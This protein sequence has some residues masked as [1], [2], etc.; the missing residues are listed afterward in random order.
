MKKIVVAAD[1]FKGSVTSGEVAQSVERGIL[2]VFPGCRVCKAYVAD[3]GEGTAQA[4]VETLGGNYVGLTV[5]D[6][7]MRPVAAR[8]G[9]VDDGGTAIVEMASASGLTLVEPD[10]RN[11]LLTTTFGS[12]ELILNA[13]ERGCRRIVI[14]I[15]GS[16]TNDA[17]TGLLQAL[18]FRFLDADG[19]PL[20]EGANGGMLSTIASIDPSEVIP[21]VGEA[22]F[23][24]ACDVTNPF[25]GPD[26]AAHVYAP[27]K[28]ADAQ[29]VATLDEGLRRF[30]GV[31]KHHNGADSDRIPG[32]GAAGGVVG[33]GKA[34]LGASLV[35]GIA[36]VLEAIHFDE[37]L[38]DADLVITGEGRL[39]AQTAM[40][41][42]PRGVLD[43][44]AR[45]GIPVIA[46]GGAVE[47]TEELLR[48][49]FAA[50]FPVVPAPVA[51]EKAMEN[52][53]ARANIERTVGQIMR[54]IALSR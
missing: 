1:S 47:G 35:P 28:G 21:A 4:L 54:L 5:R 37:M 9:I 41:K 22:E 18:G 16:A 25:S 10:R 32:A 6:P 27:Q 24:V 39:D 51:L 45:Q 43:A 50:V 19:D 36:V 26:G 12:G 52:G 13:L 30:A 23:I 2:S 31:V 8:Y 53:Y 38:H 11:P 17:G 7:L 34:L 3:G 48:Q 40:G 46:I 29:A 14:G 15:G 42:A 49:G 33:G 44:A 20:P